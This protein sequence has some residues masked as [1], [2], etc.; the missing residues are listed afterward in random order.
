M[1]VLM[2]RWCLVPKFFNV[3]ILSNPWPL[4]IKPMLA[5]LLQ[6]WSTVLS[7]CWDTTMKRFEV[8]GRL[9]INN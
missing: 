5:T 6:C 4:K 3:T 2:P 1:Y 7:E 9:S 8:A